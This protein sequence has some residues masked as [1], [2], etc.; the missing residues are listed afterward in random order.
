MDKENICFLWLIVKTAEVFRS[1]SAESIASS[2]STIPYA[3]EPFTYVI[4]AAKSTTPTITLESS[5][6]SDDE[7]RSL[8][9][10][11]IPSNVVVYSAPTT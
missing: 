7:I 4:Q 6:E 5:D 9:S 1:E 10:H 11:F 3:E 8:E 2:A